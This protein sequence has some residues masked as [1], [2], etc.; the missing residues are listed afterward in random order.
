MVRS[1]MD[2]ADLT[3]RYRLAEGLIAAGAGAEERTLSPSSWIC[4]KW[5]S[6]RAQLRQSQSQSH[7]CHNIVI[8]NHD[9]DQRLE[10]EMREWAVDVEVEEEEG[11]LQY[12]GERSI[13]QAPGAGDSQH[14]AQHP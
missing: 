7:R 10:A 11:E 4:R 5:P 1:D 6:W 12:M 9:G 13:S 14:R 3:E 8:I 2:S